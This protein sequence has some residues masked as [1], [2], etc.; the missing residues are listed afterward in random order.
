L[1]ESAPDLKAK[2]GFGLPDFDAMLGGGVVK[3]STTTLIGPSGI[4]KTLIAL[5]FLEAGVSRG[6]RCVY[7]GFYESPERLIAKAEAVSI[8]L[9]DAVADGRMIIEWRP[10]V[11]LAIDELAAELLSVVKGSGATRLVVDGVEGFHDS[12][13]RSERFG[14]FL[15][16]LTHRLRQESVTTLLTE[17]LPLYGDMSHGGSI[18]ASAMT[19]NIVLL[20]YVETSTSLYR[21]I[22][23]VKQREAAHDPSIRRFVIDENG[24]H[25]TDGFIGTTTLLSARGTIPPILSAQD[26]GS[27]T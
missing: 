21:I 23:I 19:E 18:R 15:N 10:A 25:L 22:S 1:R 4:G 7:F 12:A 26:A 17:E 5:K 24:L 8:K 3:G 20:R 27:R 11:E 13:N 16:A 6:E 2:L 14:L 9:A